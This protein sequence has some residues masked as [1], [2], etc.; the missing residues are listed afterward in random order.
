MTDDQ[1]SQEVAGSGGAG[2]ESANRLTLDVA[3]STWEWGSRDDDR[4]RTDLAELQQLLQRDL[5]G[6]LRH[7]P[8]ATTK[9]LKGT[10]EWG[11]LIVDLGTAGAFAAAAASFQSWL[12]ARP[13]RRKLVIKYSAKSNEGELV[14]DGDGI[15]SEALAEVAQKAL[16]KLP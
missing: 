4:W 9:D 3:P 11:Q 2:S 1:M 7:P 14:L 6:S 12:S 8:D 16:D 13:G 15:T 10:A 5:P